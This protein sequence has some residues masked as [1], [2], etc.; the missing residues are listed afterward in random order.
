M[1]ELKSN[2]ALRDKV[3]RIAANEQGSNPAG[4]QAILE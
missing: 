2:P 3:M 1:A 4:T